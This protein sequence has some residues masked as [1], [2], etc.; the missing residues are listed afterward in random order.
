[1]TVNNI[2]MVIEYLENEFPE[3]SV[4]V[5]PSDGGSTKCVIRHNSNEYEYTI[6]F[7]NPMLST[8]DEQKI[9]SRL[10]SENIKDKLLNSGSIR[11]K[12]TGDRFNI[13]VVD[14]QS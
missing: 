3:C 1:M 6:V 8:N 11:I 4:E 7:S 12:V 2:S 5:T 10:T 9:I 13:D 14:C